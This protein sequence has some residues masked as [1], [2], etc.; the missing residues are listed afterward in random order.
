MALTA[1]KVRTAGPGRHS[2]GHGLY[3]VVR[4]PSSRAWM[5][6]MQ[7]K[8][9]R[10]DFGLGPVHDVSLSDARCLAVELRKMIRSGKDPV[11]ERGLRRASSPTF[12]MVTRRCYEAMKSGWK[13]RRNVSWIA[14]F[15]NHVFGEIGAK[16]IE[17]IDS[18]QVLKV[19]EPIWLAKPDTARRLLQ[20]IGTVLDYAH[21]KGMIPAEISLRSVT[22]GLPRQNRQ[23]EHRAA[24]PYADVPAFLKKLTRQD[25]SIGRDAL[26]LTILTAVR[27]NETRYATWEEFDLDASTWSIPAARMKMKQPHVV[28]LSAPALALLKRLRAEHEALD[29]LISVGRM[30]FTQSGKKPISD[31][32][33][34]KAIRDMKI[35]T[36]T[37]HGFRSSFADWA[38]ECTSFPKE[39][40][41]KALAHRV[42]NAVEAAYR[43]TDFF[44]KR[45]ALMAKW[46]EYLRA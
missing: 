34:L 38:A 11:K 36:I 44:E 15:E 35:E 45:R 46:A 40:A 28:P 10:R 22:R 23:V 14:S 20:R 41:E 37:V 5:L 42:P 30:L 27:S 21:I 18:V 32:T 7:F 29:G 2:D 12:E 25:R 8:G 9:R 43:R 19:L 13:D 3:L 31:T 6:R 33:M 16:R 17:A 39:I 1:L 24:M 26:Q 4:P